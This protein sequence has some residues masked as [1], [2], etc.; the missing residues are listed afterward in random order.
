MNVML[1]HE[2]DEAREVACRQVGLAYRRIRAG[3]SHAGPCVEIDRFELA[4]DS[5]FLP[6]WEIVQPNALGKQVVSSDRGIFGSGDTR[7]M[8]KQA[9]GRPLPR[10]R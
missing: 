2:K 3:K 8:Q 4:P 9:N 10:L 5:D 7:L 6:S 1:G